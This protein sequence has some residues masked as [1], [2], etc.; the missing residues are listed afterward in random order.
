VP[1]FVILEHRGTERYKPGVHWDLLLE[2]G[3]ILK[4]WE[5]PSHPLECEYQL[6]TS[7][8]DHRLFYLEYAG[9]VADDRGT[10]RPIFGGQYEIVRHTTE[11]L[12]L[13]FVTS[14][15]ASGAIVLRPEPENEE[16]WRFELRLEP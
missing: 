15:A 9:P 16:Q 11:L 7:L 6:V 14:E 13:R 2:W 5:L 12:S 1:R 4:A 3:E 8:P 10:V